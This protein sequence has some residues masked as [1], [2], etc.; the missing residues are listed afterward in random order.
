MH[1]VKELVQVAERQLRNKHIRPLA[2]YPKPVI[3]ISTEYPGVW[4]EHCYDAVMWA[5]LFPDG[6]ETMKNTLEMFISYQREDG[7]LPCYVRDAVVGY[8]QVQECV[9]FAR[10]SLEAYRI[11][12]DRD[13]L[14]KCYVASERWAGWL[15]RNRMTTG[16][17]LVEMFVGF[18]TGHDNSGRLEGLSCPGKYIGHDASELPP[19][20]MIA[21]V[22]AVDMS[23]NYYGTLVSLAKM[24][25]ILGIKNGYTR[26]AR[27]V[28]KRLIEV[29]YDKDDAFFYDVDKNGNRRKYLSSTVLHLFLEHVLDPTEDGEMI[30]EILDRHVLN[31]EE[32]M[33]RVPFP[34]MAVCDPSR[35]RHK[36]PNSWGY[37]SEA[38]IALRCTLWMDEYG[39][40]KEFD[41][42]CRRWVDGLTRSFDEVKFG[43]ELDPITG[44]PSGC[45]EWYSSAMLF[46]IY[47]ARRLRL[48]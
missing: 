24:G 42:L 25:E 48:A 32:F 22:I 47:A 1:T 6:I 13:L 21:P 16:C 44:E 27:E 2:T 41:S 20:D 12:G 5:R 45:S 30:R 29:C 33:T 4:L 18:D 14:H 10:L 40:G 28:K 23:C 36:K 31:P 38:L 26:L 8:T 37:Y 11:C 19:D 7:Q 34:S 3:V 15:E 39:L 35:D 17:G 46:Y 9:S 43:Q